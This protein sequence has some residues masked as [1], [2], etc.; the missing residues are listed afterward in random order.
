MISLKL[1]VDEPD[2]VEKINK[3]LTPQIR[4][5]GIE[6]TIGSFSCYQACDSRWYEYFLPT[7]TLLPPHPSSYL[8]QRMEESADEMND[9]DAHEGRQEEVKGFWKDVEENAIKPVLN[10]LDDDIRAI[11]SKAL[12]EP[13]D[14]IP[15]IE[16]GNEDRTALHA[17]DID[18][19]SK[20]AAS[21]GLTQP[22]ERTQD[23]A[24]IIDAPVLHDKAQADDEIQPRTDTV[25]G[26]TATTNAPVSLPPQSLGSH[27]TINNAGDEVPPHT[28]LEPSRKD[29]LQEATKR[30]KAAYEKAKRA[31]RV[32]KKRIERL[33]EAL[34]SYVG[35]QN[36]WNYTIQKT[37][38]DPS[39]KRI[40]KS[41]V[42]NPNPIIIN[43][44]EWLSLKVHGQSFMMHQIRKMVGMAT[45]LVRCGAPLSRINESYGSERWSIPKV[46]G[47]GLLLERPV[48][49]TYNERQA[50]KFERETLDFS[51]YEKELEAFKQKEIYQRIFDE[52]AR[53]NT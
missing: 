19:S 37:F 36:Y 2:I 39:A 25:N 8:A 32:P 47:L 48:F 4:V 29:V 49:D 9:R 52:E 7:H 35:T 20:L 31:Y 11:V 43:G 45:L 15:Q 51:K 12:Y 14:G 40:I 10:S 53:D 5:W 50:K 42:V 13:E 1:I 24:I 33:Q 30:L 6:R 22:S 44:T 18:G 21:T 28:P 38:R 27:E 23:A 26:A 41:F 16:P 46:P 3:H 34:E 17:A